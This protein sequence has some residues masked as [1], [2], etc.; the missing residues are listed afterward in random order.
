M[1]SSLQNLDPN[2]NEWARV[3]VGNA[4]PAL[5]FSDALSPGAAAI[6]AT[7][8]ARSQG[9][10]PERSPTERDPLLPKS[11]RK[12][13]DEEDEDKSWFWKAGRHWCVA[14]QISK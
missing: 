5:A 4:D 7:E 9:A 14:T 13:V 12:G 8:R 1:A 2:P 10:S 3:N 6:D 11:V